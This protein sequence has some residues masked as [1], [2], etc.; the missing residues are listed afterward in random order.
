MDRRALLAAGLAAAGALAM[1]S[2]ALPQPR[3]PGLEVLEPLY[4]V[5]ASARRL[6]IR[7]G[8]RGCTAKDDFSFLVDRRPGEPPQIAFGRRRAE[9]CRPRKARLRQ[10]D[11]A[12]T[13]EELGL[14][15]GAP[16]V[17]LNPIAHPAPGKPAG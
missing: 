12:F 6:T 4:A 10:V 8:T 15:P 11:I 14:E 9:D 1:G 17:V 13:Y 5:N 3:P 7:V 16:V 2:Q